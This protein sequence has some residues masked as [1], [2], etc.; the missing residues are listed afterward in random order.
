MNHHYF[1]LFC[2]LLK[3]EI[4][5]LYQGTVLG[6]FWLLVKPLFLLLIY[7]LVF[8]GIMKAR[9]PG[10]SDDSFEFAIILFAGLIVF[11]LFAEILSSAPLVILK[12]QTYVKKVVFPLQILP[13]VNLGTALFQA[14]IALFILLLFQLLHYGVIPLTILLLPLVWLPF[15]LLLAGLSYLL[16]ALGVFVRDIAQTMSFIIPGFMFLSPI[17]YPVS[18]LPPA[19]QHWI[20]LNPLSFM[21]EQTR[22]VMIQGVMPAWSGWLWYF[23]V[24]LLIALPG[25]LFFTRTRK[26]FA[27]VL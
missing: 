22:A 9:W 11:N 23:L 21:V 19:A 27:D 20:Y 5:S 3:R 12:N 24:A 18:A 8:A 25:W 26:G 2:Q 10:S 14:A 1:S 7:T 16:S 6:V 17:F 13:L 15:L 4:Q